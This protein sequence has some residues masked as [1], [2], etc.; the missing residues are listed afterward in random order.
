MSLFK[1][2]ETRKRHHDLLFYM[3]LTA[4][5]IAAGLITLTAP[6][7]S[8][9]EGQLFTT[10]GVNIRAEADSTSRI[11]TAVSAGTLV[12]VLERSGNWVKVQTEDHTGYIYGE[13]LS[14]E[15]P[16]V[17]VTVEEDSSADNTSA[18][19]K[20]DELRNEAISYAE[21]RLG[22][23]YSQE[24]RNEKGFADC[25]SLVRDSFEEASGGVYIGDNTRLQTQTMQ[26]YLY[27]IKSLSEV[28]AGDIVYHIEKDDNHTGIYLG[29]GKVV[30]ASK[31]S[32]KVKITEFAEE[33]T[34]WQYGCDAASYCCASQ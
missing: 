13:Y 16:S 3:K 9:E 28:H 11:C 24:K 17:T 7:V 8:A 23:A 15:D 22:D 30:H 32:G 26:S 31:T 33:S 12:T 5:V 1:K 20:T 10:D 25:S 19:T 29:N 27:P 4:S 2:P 34:Y 18:D 14:E 21:S 6:A